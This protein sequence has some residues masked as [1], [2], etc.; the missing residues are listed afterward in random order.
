MQLQ[1]ILHVY[2]LLSL[3]CLVLEKKE[4]THVTCSPYSAKWKNVGQTFT[5][6]LSSVCIMSSTKLQN[7]LKRN[8]STTE[9]VNKQTM[10]EK[11]WGHC[12][13]CMDKYLI[14]GNVGQ[15]TFL[16]NNNMVSS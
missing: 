7:P 5:C 4:G 8:M 9:Y 1:P 16:G 12:Q 10:H 3:T 11:G 13:I 15:I 2:L 6:K 14:T